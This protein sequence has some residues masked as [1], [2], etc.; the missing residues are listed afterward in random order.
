MIDFLHFQNNHLH[1]TLVRG[2]D[3]L[4]NTIMNVDV[5]TGELHKSRKFNKRGE[6]IF[7]GE[8][9]YSEYKGLKITYTPKGK[10]VVK[11][12][13]HKY[14]NEGVHNHNDFS[15]VQ[16][17][18]TLNSFVKQFQIP[19]DVSLIKGL[20]I[21]VNIKL[22]FSPK[23]V[24]DNCFIHKGVTPEMKYD[25]RKGHYVQFEHSQYIIKIYNKSLQYKSQGL[26]VD[27]NIMRFE[28]KFKKMEILNNKFGIYALQD[29]LDFNFRDFKPLLLQKW[30]EVLMYDTTFIS[31]HPNEAKY[32][33]I[34]TWKAYL[35]EKSKNKLKYHRKKYNTLAQQYS[36]RR[37]QMIG[38]LLEDKIDLLIYEPKLTNSL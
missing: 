3:L 15:E 11:G 25:S 23:T 18:L 27:N 8:Y 34:K 20:E 19:L 6:P 21:G 31:Q 13:L 24:I 1:Q 4:S 37:K 9:Y 36:Q 29:L 7:K 28:I 14:W 16:S 17:K 35:E 38:D 26:Q 12:S 22:P 5:E 33:H 2:S 10:L 32:Q 30:D